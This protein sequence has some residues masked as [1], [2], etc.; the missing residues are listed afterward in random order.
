MDHAIL[1]TQ[2]T[3]RQTLARSGRYQA[4]PV[5]LA[6]RGVGSVVGG[7]AALPVSRLQLKR[8]R[9]SLHYAA[10]RPSVSLRPPGGRSRP[11]RPTRAGSRPSSGGSAPVPTTRPTKNPH[12]PARWRTGVCSS[13]EGGIR[14]PETVSRLRDFQSRSFSL[15]DTSPANLPRRPKPGRRLKGESLGVAK[16]R[17]PS[18][19]GPSGRVTTVRESWRGPR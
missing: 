4:V 11:P 3:E 1:A 2:R 13:G 16:S 10:E 17:L 5:G 9:R 14:T 15:S 19:C 12:P 6:S 18:A 8:G 7:T